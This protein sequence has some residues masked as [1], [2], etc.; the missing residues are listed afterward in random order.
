MN[1]VN[2]KI[3]DAVIKKAE[4]IC[5]ESLALIGIYGSVASGDEYEKSDL[6]LLILIQDNRGWQLGTGFILED[7]GIGYDIY[8]TNWDG[9]REDSK[10]HHAQISKLMDS[11]IVYIKNQQAYEELCRLREQTRQFLASEKRDQRVDELIDK[12]KIAFANAYLHDSLGQVRMDACEVIDDLCD[13]M[14]LFHGRYFRLGVKRMLEELASIGVDDCFLAVIKKIVVC[15]ELSEMR[16][17]LG[18]LLAYSDIHLRKKK[19]KAAP[20]K[21]LAG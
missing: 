5:P 3:I 12:A 8:C 9:L 18:N 7:S 20:S 21:D 4:K 16:G 11:K 15:K 19:E 2:Q 6:D 1:E 17:L 13:A 14:M 10:C